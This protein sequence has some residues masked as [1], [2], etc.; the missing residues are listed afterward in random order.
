MTRSN[1]AK[2]KSNKTGIMIAGTVALI[3]S[4]VGLLAGATI[5]CVVT[6]ASKVVALGV[7]PK[8]TGII[9]GAVGL[10]W[11]ARKTLKKK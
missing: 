6:A 9:G 3:G 11:G 8:I 10:G 7:V 4:G 1:Q 2:S 5:T